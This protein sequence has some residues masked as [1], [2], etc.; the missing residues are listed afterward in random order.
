MVENGSV[1]LRRELLSSQS[2]KHLRNDD[3]EYEIECVS[4]RASGK[5]KRGAVS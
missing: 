4:P 2:G 3:L 1:I 5:P